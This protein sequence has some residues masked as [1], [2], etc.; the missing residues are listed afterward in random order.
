[1]LYVFFKLYFF[2]K[3]ICRAV[4]VRAH[5]PAFAVRIQF[6]FEFAFFTANNRRFKINPAALAH[7]HN[8]VA[9]FVNRLPLYFLAAVRA[10]RNAYAG[11]QQTHI[12]VNFGNRTHGRTRVV[13]CCFLVD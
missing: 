12:I 3:F 10:M 13:V 4:Y 7:F 1:M 2:R 9:N 11:E 8:A 5:E 6:L